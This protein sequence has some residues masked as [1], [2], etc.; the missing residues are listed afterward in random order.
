MKLPGAT[1]D[2]MAWVTSSLAIKLDNNME[3]LIKGGTL[4]GDCAYMK[5]LYMATHL[6]RFLGGHK[7]TYNFYLSQ[8]RITIEQAIGVLVH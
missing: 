7:D 5:K 2:Y 4:V 3:K 8:L 6:K 1:S